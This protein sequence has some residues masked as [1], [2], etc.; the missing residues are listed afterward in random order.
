M[1][2]AFVDQLQQDFPDEEHDLIKALNDQ[3]PTSIRL[4]HRKVTSDPELDKVPWHP[5]A[6]Y[7]NE[8]PQF[9]LDPWFHAGAYYVQEASS[10]IIHEILNTLDISKESSFLD[11]AAAPGGKSQILAEFLNNEGMLV[12]NEVIR[13][14]ANILSEN[15]TKQGYMN[16]VVSNSD[17]S[18]FGSQLVSY[19]D[20]VL[21]DA[22]CSGEGMFRKDPDS[23]TEWSADNVK[24]CS[25]RQDRIIRESLSCLKPGGVFI[26]STCT[27]N[28]EENENVIQSYLKSAE[29][30]IIDLEL[31]DFNL[32]KTEN[33]FHRMF[34]NRLKGE[35]LS[36]GVYRK[37]SGDDS[38]RS[39]KTL[40]IHPLKHQTRIQKFLKTESQV[41]E[42]KGSLYASNGFLM[43]HLNDLGSINIVQAST[44]L[45]KDLKGK[46][47]PA[48]GL[49]NSIFIDRSSFPQLDL[50]LEESLDYLRKSNLKSQADQ[51][52]WHLIRF[53]GQNLGWAKNIGKRWN[54]YYPNQWALKKLGSDSLWHE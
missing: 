18:R 10:M 45:G 29:L 44:E 13:S 19:F 24:L 50:E 7:L 37:L 53:K 46:F 54:N 49:A 40:N 11:I 34:P 25:A 41:Y 22:P 51:Q 42:F 21:L 1:K 14:R 38:I 43:E 17:P 15:M 23:R 12:S 8:R 39:S 33:G 3:A 36:F 9:S 20:L 2:K 27:F 16:V 47:I 5:H 48:Q 26:Y 31:S 35:G 28:K 6:Y 52:G 32:I 4:N 30:E